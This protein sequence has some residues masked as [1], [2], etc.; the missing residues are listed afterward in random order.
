MKG[1]DERKSL[2]AIH[3]VNVDQERRTNYMVTSGR[4]GSGNQRAESG[5]AEDKK[6]APGPDPL[7]EI[8]GMKP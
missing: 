7:K 4:G 5:N 6:C 2:H 3:P 8:K 1:G